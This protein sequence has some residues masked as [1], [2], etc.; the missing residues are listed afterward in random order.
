MSKLHLILVLAFAPC[1]ASAQSQEATS[2]ADDEAAIRKAVDSYVKAF[3]SRDAKSVAMHWSP[4]AVYTSRTTGEQVTGREA[5]EAQFAT[6][7][8]DNPQAKIAATPQSIQFVSPNVAVEHGTAQFLQAEEEPAESEYTAVYVRRD[9]NWLLDRV[10]EEEVPIV[11]SNYEQLKPLEWIIGNWVDEDENASIVTECSWTRNNN[12]ITRSFTVSVGDEIDMAGMQI[13]GWDPAAKRIRS[14]TFDSDGGFAEG[15]WT[16]KND[17]WFVRKSGML[18]DGRQA[19]SLNIIKRID[20][21]TI[22]VQSIN[23]SVAGEL[24]PNIDEVR[25]VRQ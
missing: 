16:S 9:G 18:Q 25:V 19:T 17:R 14:W 12:F 13:I 8:K 6:I 20:D 21:D 24:L 11:Q 3:N 23:R 22:T 2:T 15:S 4:D 1:A 7:F 10:T 5:I